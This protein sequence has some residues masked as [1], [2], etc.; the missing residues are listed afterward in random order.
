[1]SNIL[2]NPILIRE[3]GAEYPLDLSLDQYEIFTSMKKL[4]L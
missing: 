1:M 4:A 3:A 2:D